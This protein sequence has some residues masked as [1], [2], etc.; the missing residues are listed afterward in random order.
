MENIPDAAW[1]QLKC[2]LNC[3]DL[4]GVEN[5]TSISKLKELFEKHVQPLMEEFISMGS[6]KSATFKYEQMC[7]KAVGIH[8]V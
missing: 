6:N 7:I 1:A 3:M 5:V 4:K 8:L 2:V